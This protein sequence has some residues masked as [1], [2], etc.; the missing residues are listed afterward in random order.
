MT[1]F[2]IDFF[3]GTLK[4]LLDECNPHLSDERVVKT[5]LGAHAWL[6][7]QFDDVNENIYPVRKFKKF[8][9]RGALEVFEKKNSH[10]MPVDNEPFCYFYADW[11]K[12]K[13]VNKN[14]KE[15]FEAKVV[16]ASWN[17]D[18]KNNSN[19][20]FCGVSTEFRDNGLKLAH[21]NDA[22]ILEGDLQNLTSSAAIK[23]RFL[24]SLS[25]LNVFLFP[26]Y[27]NCTFKSNYN[28]SRKDWAED[29][30]I[31]QIAL[32]F[33]V[34][35]MKISKEMLQVF[36]PQLI[37]MNDWEERADGIIIE[38]TPRSI[39]K[40]KSINKRINN[41]PLRNIPTTQNYFSKSNQ[42][43]S[44][45]DAIEKYKTWRN[46]NPEVYRLDGKNPG[47]PSNPS[48]WLKFSVCGYDNTYSFTAENGQTFFG[49]DYNGVVNFHGDARC[50]K[51][52]DFVELFE[53]VEDYRDILVPFSTQIRKGA[54]RPKFGLR[55]YEEKVDGFYLYHDEWSDRHK[56]VT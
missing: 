22:G 43:Y 17:C 52:D 14:I 41:N 45:N 51:I 15:L 25:P 12:N 24:R 5:F 40:S 29:S 30:E 9:S 13:F 1:N 3:K 55:G 19:M 18:S 36:F 7:S 49:D 38:V 46:L 2:K 33:L 34:S 35:K 47:D 56:K 54:V 10:F 44:I 16:P 31:R 6:I 50:E 27:R 39:I 53:Q 26:N 20:K 21:I 37:F 42:V 11:L 28:P 8:N 4:E 48:A 23:I 32:S